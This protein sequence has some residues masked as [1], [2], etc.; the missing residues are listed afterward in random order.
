MARRALAAAMAAALLAGPASAD[1]PPQ[2]APP[3]DLT[4][5][6]HLESG[7]HVSTDGGSKIDLPRGYFVDEP[8]WD[9]IDQDV[10]ATQVLQTRLLAEN[11][12]MRKTLSGWQPGWYVITAALAVG[13]IGGWYVGRKL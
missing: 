5:Y 11:A 7:S 9:K 10:K 1:N 8:T 13:L 3:P 6:V 4:H 2:P 12:S